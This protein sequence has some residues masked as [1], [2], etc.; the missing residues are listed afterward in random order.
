MNKSILSILSAGLSVG[1]A[2]GCG[3]LPGGE[4]VAITEPY[5]FNTSIEEVTTNPAF[6]GYGLGTSTVAEG[7]LDRAVEFWERQSS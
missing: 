2:C 5:T 4:T 7:W 1:I 3:A 6:G